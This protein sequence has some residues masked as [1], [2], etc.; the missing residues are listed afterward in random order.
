LICICRAALQKNK[1]VLMDEATANIDVK[2]EELIQELIYKEFKESTV[3]TIAH[4]LNTI[5]QSDRVLVLHHGQKIEY[6]HPKTLMNDP[7]TVFSQLVKEI[8]KEEEKEKK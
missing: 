6:D 5:I 8:E 2:T 4:R 7:E 1:V 3:M